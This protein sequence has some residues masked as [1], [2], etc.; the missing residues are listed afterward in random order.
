MA[1][2][3]TRVL[4]ASGLD[5]LTIRDVAEVGLSSMAGA[6]LPYAVHAFGLEADTTWR[7]A[8]TLFAIGWVGAAW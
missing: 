5:K 8:S 7:L 1:A 6:L 2:I 4:A 3:A